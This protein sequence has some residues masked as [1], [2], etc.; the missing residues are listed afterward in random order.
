MMTNI[1]NKEKR[2]YYRM[3]TEATLYLNRNIAEKMYNS[4]GLRRRYL[5][6]K[7]E[8]NRKHIDKMLKKWNKLIYEES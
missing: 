8:R 1:I 5:K 7:Y 2:E 4:T 6:Y 3:E